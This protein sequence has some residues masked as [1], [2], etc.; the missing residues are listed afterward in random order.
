M[1][2]YDKKVIY[3]SET[4]YGNRIKGAGFVK[5]ECRGES[6]SFDV[7]ISGLW[8]LTEK[9]YDINVISMQ[10]KEYCIGKIF[11]HGGS[12]EWKACYGNGR[13]TAAGDG[14]G[15]GGGTGE[16]GESIGYREIAKLLVRISDT[17][18]VVGNLPVE[19]K[20]MQ[21]AELA[22][23]RQADGKAEG[24]GKEGAEDRGKGKAGI[25]KSGKGKW[26]NG[27]PEEKAGWE[28]REVKEQKEERKEKTERK[29][30]EDRAEAEIQKEKTGKEMAEG[31]KGKKEEAGGDTGKEKGIWRFVRG[32]KETLCDGDGADRQNGGLETAG[33]RT[34]E[35]GT[36]I[37][38]N[39]AAW[40]KS[41]EASLGGMEKEEPKPR[42]E[43]VK[44]HMDDVILND[45][46]DQLKQ[47]YSVVHPYEDDRQY[48]AIQPKDFV[49][50]TGDYQ[51][52]ANNSFLLHGFYN[53]RHIILGREQDD[54]FYLGVPGVYYEREKMVALM[55]GF[56]AFECEGG[57]P[58]SGKFG[59]YLRRV[60][61]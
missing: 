44:L 61:I 58:E 19:K 5:M 28:K 30:T 16:S 18:T 4:E 51:H 29:K 47:I 50:M 13:V 41:G 25:A 12:G 52:L 31:E 39:T 53:Y 38:E 21:A 36:G 35:T 49:I 42:K 2:Y 9:K 10:G 7:H 32:G 23:D 40:K 55:F 22:A 14:S 33:R 1:A 45:K 56:E 34:K 59:Y 24:K 6:C 57:I 26:E 37:T 17:K 15:E 46:W 48:I 43:E 60:K 27:K 20:T 3:L 11:L 54:S 8:E